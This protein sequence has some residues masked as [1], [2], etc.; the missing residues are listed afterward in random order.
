M[1]LVAR[2]HRFVAFIRAQIRTERGANLIEYAFLLTL[3]VVICIV[4]VTFIGSKT[5][6]AFS[7]AGASF[8]P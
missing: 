8:Q 3:I 4:A 5:S 7:G 6:S 1:D 2:S